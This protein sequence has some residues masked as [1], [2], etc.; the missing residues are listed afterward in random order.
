MHLSEDS[1]M[2]AAIQIFSHRATDVQTA[3]PFLKAPLC[4]PCSDSIRTIVLTG[5]QK[6]DCK[7]ADHSCHYMLCIFYFSLMS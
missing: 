3:S 6:T 5:Y 7:T 4:L 2:Q 1:A